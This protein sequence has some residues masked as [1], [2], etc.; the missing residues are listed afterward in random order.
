MTPNLR[1]FLGVFLLSLPLWWGLNVAGERL[2]NFFF[3]SELARNPQMF[4]AQASL[5]TKLWEMLPSRKQ[6][7]APLELGASSA[8]SVFVQR[9]SQES[10]VLFEKDAQKRIP[11]A[12]LSKLM[13][14]LVVARRY[15]LD[16]E[17]VVSRVAVAEEENFGELKEGDSFTHFDLLRPMLMESSNDASAAFALE[18]GMANFLNLMN[19]E[20][21]SLGLFDTFFANHAGLDPDIPGEPLNYSTARDLFVLTRHLKTFYSSVFEILGLK[22]YPLYT[23]DGRFHHMMKNT[24]E[25]LASNGWPTRVLGGKTGWTPEAQGG[26]VLVLESPKGKGY[27]VNIVLGSEQRFRDMKELVNWVFDSWRF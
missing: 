19:Q 9:E 6:S 26:L 5:E 7:A 17:I 4:T 16:K 20:A 12:S 1:I 24:N 15:P 25:L 22:E 13:G 21:D 11:I 18:I 8:L 10:K 14:A 2:E 3:W 23:A 27:L